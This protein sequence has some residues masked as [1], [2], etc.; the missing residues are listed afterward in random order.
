M[1]RV[2]SVEPDGYA[3]ELGLLAGDRLLSIN[4]HEITDLVDY[5]LHIGSERLVLALSL[6][7]I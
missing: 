4:G 5:H 3:A 2:E 1:L 6:I 7:H